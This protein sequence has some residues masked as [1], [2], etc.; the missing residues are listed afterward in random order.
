MPMLTAGPE[1]LV[2]TTT[3][4]DQHVPQ[5]AALSGGGFIVVWQDRSGSGGD[6]SGYS[7]KAQRF[8]AA[9]AKVGGE[10]LVNVNASGDQ[11]EPKVT[12]LQSGG[13]VVTWTDVTGDAGG[14]AVKARIYDA[15]G[16]PLGGEFLVN[17]LTAHDQWQPVPEA[18]PGGG[19]VVT[20]AHRSGDSSLYAVKGQIF[21]PAGAKVGAEFLVN[22][23]EFLYQDNGKVSALAS[24]GF[25]V[26]WNDFSHSGGD[27]SGYS[28]KAQIYDPSGS[29]VG[30][31]FLV[32]STT[33][34]DQGVTSRSVTGLPSG[35]FVVAW[36]DNSGAGPDPSGWSI[37]G[38]MFD[39]AGARVGGEFVVNTNTAGDQTDPVVL[40]LPSG[41]FLVAWQDSTGD[42][43]GHA[44]KA[45]LFDAAGARSG[46]EFLVNATASS[47]QVQPAIGAFGSGFVAVWADNSGT[48]GDPSGLGVVLR[49]FSPANVINGTPGDDFIT[50][51]PGDDR[52]SGLAGNDTLVG[53]GGSDELHGGD[54]NDLLRGD[55]FNNYTGPSG[56]DMLHGGAG[57]DVMWTSAGV[58]F[59]DGGDGFDRVSLF[60]FGATQAA[61]ASLVT[62]TIANDGFGNAE[63]MVSIEAL[64]A[65]TAFADHFTGND[66]ANFLVGDRGDTLIGNGGGDLFQVGGAPALLDGGAGI[67]TISLFT[68]DIFGSIRPDTSGDGLA[69]LVFA[70]R[71]VH[72]DLGLGMI[73]DDGFG[74]SGTLTG[75]ENVGGSGLD[76]IL[77]GDGGANALTGYEGDD[78][79]EGRGGNDLI[80]GGDGIDTA[81]YAAASGGVTVNL[82]AGIAAGADGND[83]LIGIEN[84]TGSGFDDLIFG[85]ASGN[86]LLGLAGNDTIQGRAG[87]D[88]I[89]GGEGNDAL[90][91]QQGND[92]LIGGAGHDFF[93]GG[94]GDDLI[95]G[96]DGFDR[97][98]FFP[99]PGDPI[100]TGV[101]VSLLLQG[102]PQDTGHGW[103]TLVGIEA[104]S[105]T[106]FDD[107]LI[108]DHG[109][110]WLIAS[111][112]N[113]D[114]LTGNGGD[115]LL[116]LA[117]GD[118][119][120]D[121]G[122][123][124]DTAS[125]DGIGA[126]PGPVTVSLALQGA[127][128]N[129]GQ[130]AMTLASIEN[131]SGSRFDDV[132]TGDNGAN[133]LAGSVGNDL[134]VGGG[135]NDV[136]LGDGWSGFDAGGAGGPGPLVAVD[137]LG[138]AYGEPAGNDTLVG[139]AGNDLLNGGGGDDVLTGGKDSDIFVFGAASGH[140]RITDFSKADTILIDVAG[141]DDF[142]DLVVASDG[143]GDA[144]I[145]W[146]TSDSL[147]LEG[148]KAKKLSAA[149]FSFGEPAAAL[150]A[151]VLLTARGK[152]DAN[153][154][155]D[156]WVV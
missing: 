29:R 73:V 98:S 9:G 41:G 20:W 10:F 108:G 154:G 2:N 69:E 45:Q 59:Y 15:S 48:A 34:A 83:T 140:D 141:I 60:S 129:T 131:L 104:L 30:G 128:Q 89:E 21:D 133:R 136:L 67:D 111:A 5:V 25:V 66:D 117:N 71:G 107:V 109:A 94:T 138:P 65:G 19:F 85:D 101:T 61:V 47:D 35:G 97:V 150:E 72:V 57:D 120:A 92:L 75:I 146:G 112:G 82:H 46:G 152:A 115:D 39:S 49:I 62:Q 11:Y 79:L 90:H 4:G 52:I 135:G 84:V 31:E 137:D 142:S 23:T 17:T 13:F 148:Y 77:I 124:V 16:A 144:V 53:L 43:S 96:G 99:S 145:S 118:H 153:A 93:R 147:T 1:M 63:T 132:L 76:D 123:G 56:N 12:A 74:N 78:L 110:N 102:S 58:D 7:V 134:L 3:S 50:G 32:N 70:T 22:T 149:D 113:G 95:D 28:V 88:R 8:D 122:N 105:G 143:N 130:G 42:G 87:D 156:S 81:S 40:A 6:A 121:G 100:G 68:G 26:V 14:W 106:P 91:G 155:A 125:F 38:Q 151:A 114:S 51:T 80:D 126:M 44:I 33:S 119:L 24:G 116:E 64:G 127:P 54:G 27:F 86:A 18:L 36:Q 37:R 139:G 103:D 55:G